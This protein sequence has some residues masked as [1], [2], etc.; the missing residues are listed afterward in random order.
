MLKMPREVS[1]WPRPPQ[2]AQVRSLEPGSAP[3][4]R[5]FAL[6]ELGDGNFLFAAERGFFERDF[7]IVAQIIAALRAG[8]ILAAAE[9]FSKMLPP[10]AA[11]EDF[12]E[13]IERIVEPAAAA[14]AA[15]ALARVK[16]RV[17]VLVVGGAFL[18]VA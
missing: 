4:P 16:G 6:V 3:E 8:R 7:H 2:V 10:A 11:A 18:R 5:R 9:M 15:G 14:A 1:T 17:A 13:N 12:A